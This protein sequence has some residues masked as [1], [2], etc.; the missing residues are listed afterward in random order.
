[1]RGATIRDIHLEDV[2]VYDSV[3]TLLGISIN[4]GDLSFGAAPPPAG[5]PL[6]IIENWFISGLDV[7][8]VGSGG[9]AAA[10]S[11]IGVGYRTP[12]KPPD[13]QISIIQT[14]VPINSW[15]Y[16]AVDAGAGSAVRGIDFVDFM[17]DGACVSRAALWP[18]LQTV[19]GTADLSFECSATAR[20][21]RRL[22]T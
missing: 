1:M 21:H 14:G 17:L 10:A 16:F 2:V 5:A 7:R 13:D 9:G 20:A 6:G 3:A 4:V 18:H 22:A 15:V 12:D 8:V 11:E 19:G